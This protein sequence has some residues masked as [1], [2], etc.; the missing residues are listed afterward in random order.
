M[1]NMEFERL[2]REHRDMEVPD[3]LETMV[4]KSIQKAK[5]DIRRRCFMKNIK[6]ATAGIAASLVLFTAAVNTSPVVADAML[7]IPLVGGI[8]RVLTVGDINVQDAGYDADIETPAIDGLENQ[9]LQDTLNQ[10]YLE[11]SRELY[12][13]F[14]SEMENLEENGGGHL[15]VASGYEIKTDNE[16]ILSI[17]R[18]VVNT[19]GSSSTTFEYDTIDKELEILITLPGLFADDSYVEII[20]E[21][22]KGQMIQQ[23]QE[24]ETRFFWV[25]GVAQSFNTGLFEKISP[26]QDFYITGENKLVISF[27]KYEVGPGAMGIVEF[28]IPS[29]ILA[30][31]LVSEEYI[32]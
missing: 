22:I 1:G 13:E 23:H 8:V 15:G 20:S 16:K 30:E 28:E 21:N 2:K 17:G 14:I 5:K 19:V 3:E 27:D 26:E 4:R 9:K 31:I 12:D 11:E 18:Y 29:E 32:R 24:D 25:E 10:K 7:K 6:I